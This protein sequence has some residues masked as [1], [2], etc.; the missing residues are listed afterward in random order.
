M[1]GVTEVLAFLAIAGGLVVAFALFQ[2]LVNSTRFGDELRKVWR[3][4]IHSHQFSAGQASLCFLAGFVLVSARYHPF[5]T[6]LGGTL[7]GCGL[8]CVAYSAGFG[9][10]LGRLNAKSQWASECF[11]EGL[12]EQVRRDELRR[13]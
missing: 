8:H 6:W 11:H 7:I 1:V 10:T 13:G 4:G 5:L 9:W 2:S 3:W 12:T